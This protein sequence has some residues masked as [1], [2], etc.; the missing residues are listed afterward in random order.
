MFTGKKINDDICKVKPINTIKV[1]KQLLLYS[2]LVLTASGAYGQNAVEAVNFGTQINSMRIYNDTIFVAT[3]QSVWFLPL[4]GERS[5]LD[6]LCVV[7]YDYLRS[8]NRQL[9][10]Y[11]DEARYMQH[12]LHPDTIY[13]YSQ[14]GNG[15]M[16]YTL[17]RSADFG[18]TWW[19]TGERD[20]QLPGC[21]QIAFNPLCADEMFLFGQNEYVDCI[22]PWVIHTTDA[23]ETL[24][25]TDFLMDSDRE[26]TLYTQIAFSP[27]DAGVLLL[28][29]TTGMARSADGGQ[30]WTWTTTGER[31]F[32][33]VCYDDSKP[34]VAYALELLP[35]PICDNGRTLYAIARSDD[36][37]LSWK[38]IAYLDVPIS[39]HGVNTGLCD[40]Q[41]HGGT[42][43]VR[44]A[45]SIYLLRAA[46]SARMETT[47]IEQHADS[48]HCT[49]APSPTLYDLSG[50]RATGAKGIVVS[51]GRKIVAK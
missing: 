1:M 5:A 11:T 49:S 25:T 32:A 12:P 40:F 8:G 29:A 33:N 23:M 18:Q 3:P 4:N 44:G 45:D 43:V 38:S 9:T 7:T 21:P 30:S 13:R 14:K 26:A 34:H 39:Q 10:V 46:A 15:S 41:C 19:T 17:S 36:D 47:A 35:Q 31:F 37:G 28:S 42:L 2:F 22:C 20:L 6:E 48:H 24:H 50:R 27:A 51:D 16:G